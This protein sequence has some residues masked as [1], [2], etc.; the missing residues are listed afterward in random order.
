MQGEEDSSFGDSEAR[1]ILDAGWRQGSIFRPPEYF[2]PVRFECD[3]EVLVVCTQS[4]T[5]VSPSIIAN[6][7][8]EYLVAEPVEK[9]HPRSDEAKGKNSHCFHLPV[10]GMPNAEAL[11]CDI[12][13][14]FFA[15][16]SVCI[17]RAPENDI[18][19]TEEGVRNLAG[20][21]ARYY[22]RV[23]LPNE[24]VARA[25]VKNGLFEIIQKALRVKDSSGDQL[26]DAVDKI[27]ITWSP[28]S[29]LQGSFYQVDIQ[30]LCRDPDAAFLLG[31]SLNDPLEPFTENNGHEGIKLV[32]DTASR[33]NTFMSAFDGY[34]RLTEW[35]YLSN[36]GDVAESEN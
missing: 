10:S 34:K 20:W 12:N 29:D 27:Y 2:V 17:G 6:P 30:F 22:T 15:D 35:D 3:R 5:V 1:K 18:T 9:Y 36:L 32:Y 25:K 28:D 19:P 13:R 4:C 23:A 16:R 24:L 33:T 14:R 31:S 26:S 21:I 8:I 7:L 11:S